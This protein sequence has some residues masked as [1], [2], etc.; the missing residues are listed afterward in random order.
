[1][2]TSNRSRTSGFAIVAAFFGIA[3]AVIVTMA[4]WW[5]LLTAS[6][7]L[8]AWIALTQA[9]HQTWSMTKVGITSIPRRLGASAIVVVGIAGVVGVLIALLAMGAGF[10]RT[11]KLTG[12]DDT[13]IVLQTGQKNETGSTISLDSIGAISQMR[14]VLRNARDEAIGSPEVVLSVSLPNRSTG[15][16]ASLALRGVGPHIWELWPGIKIR[17]GRVFQPGLR[18]LIAGKDASSRFSGLKVGSSVKLEGQSWAVVG[19]FDSGDA[20]N[21]EIWGDTQALSSAYHREGFANSLILRLKGPGALEMLRTNVESDPRL[22]VYVQ[23]TR[24]YFGQQSESFSRMMSI[25]GS[26]IGAIMAVGAIFGAI[27]ATYMS[28][29]G[30]T[31]EI[32]TL[33]ALGFRRLPVIASV[34]LE[35]MILAALGGTLGA[36]LAWAIFD[37]FTAVTMG[38]TGQIVFALDVSPTLVCD[39]I[40]WALAIGFVGGLIPAARAASQSIVKGLRAT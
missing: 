29:E 27:N 16:D 33:R 38:Q 28:I 13:A 31:R 14:P 11:L 12:S 6:A 30:R 39:G 23:T 1:V 24:A 21:S 20:H 35:T 5:L 22:K 8:V 17:E 3:I 26:A 7:L 4:P 36:F 2:N 32:S 37:G 9:G 25:V 10:E 19:A 18:E 40:K 34:L 15:L